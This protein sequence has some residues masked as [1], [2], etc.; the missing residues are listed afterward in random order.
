MY[1]FHLLITSQFE[2]KF[3]A[4]SE[5]FSFFSLAE[6]QKDLVWKALDTG[7]KKHQSGL[8]QNLLVLP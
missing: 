2:M 1:I 7:W 8:P 5:L 3:T 6:K 4:G